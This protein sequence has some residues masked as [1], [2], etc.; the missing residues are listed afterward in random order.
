MNSLQLYISQHSATG[1]FKYTYFKSFSKNGY[2][3]SFH[4]KCEFVLSSKKVLITK[5]GD[6]LQLLLP[7]YYLSPNVCDIIVS[8][9]ERLGY[10][11]KDSK[12]SVGYMEVTVFLHLIY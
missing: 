2:L 11:K 12:F 9:S 10:G 8:I 3:Y 7:F 1:S 4:I 6:L 5:G